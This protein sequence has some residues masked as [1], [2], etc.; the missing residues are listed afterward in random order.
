MGTNTISSLLTAAA[1]RKTKAKSPAL[2]AYDDNNGAANAAYNASRSTHFT[3]TTYYPS[4][5]AFGQCDLG[6]TG[7][8]GDLFTFHYTSATGW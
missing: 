1:F 7:T 4:T 8:A 2:V 5:T 3:V 6:A